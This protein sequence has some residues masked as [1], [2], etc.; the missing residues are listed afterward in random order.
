MFV[1]GASQIRH[2]NRVMALL[3]QQRWKARRSAWRLKG[4]TRVWRSGVAK[5]AT[6]SFEFSLRKVCPCLLASQDVNVRA[7]ILFIGY[8][9]SG[10]VL[11][12]PSALLVTI[13]QGRLTP[14]LL[15]T[16]TRKAPRRTIRSLLK[17]GVGD[18][19]LFTYY[20]QS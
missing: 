16:V 20:H 4:K 10:L 3:R 9:W 2:Q 19:T 1:F 17:T 13:M 12:Q 5:R 7:R 6:L 15:R 8:W 11:A 18:Q 14:T